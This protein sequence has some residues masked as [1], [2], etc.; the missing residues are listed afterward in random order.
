MIR[1]WRYGSNPFLEV[2]PKSKYI[3]INQRHNSFTSRS[4]TTSSRKDY[5]YWI[6]CQSR[7]MRLSVVHISD[8][9]GPAS[10]TSLWTRFADGDANIRRSWSL[11]IG[12]KTTG[13]NTRTSFR[14]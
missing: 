7:K 4:A 5:G 2:S 6:A 13:R 8:Y 10:D 1:K 14:S 3:R 12:G 11:Y 9:R